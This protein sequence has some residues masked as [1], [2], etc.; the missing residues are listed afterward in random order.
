MDKTVQDPQQTVS[1]ENWS[2]MFDSWLSNMTN[3]I[4]SLLDPW[5]LIQFGLIGACYIAALGLAHILEK[6]FETAIRRISG[7]PR[8]LR[9]LAVLL[10]RM[11]WIVFAV[12]LW[13][14]AFGLKQVTW[15]SRSYFITVAANLVTAWVIIAIVSR[16]IRNRTIAKTFA[17][18]A[19]SLAT[20]NILGFLDDTIAIL[21]KLAFTTGDVRISVLNVAQAILVCGVLVW[22]ANFLA[23]FIEKQ[24][25]GNKDLTPSLQ[26]LISKIAKV[27]LLALAF[28]MS[29]SVA[30]VDLTVLTIF[31]GA[32]GLGIGFGLQKVVSNL[33]SGTIILLDKSIKPGDVISLGEKFG[34]ITSLRARYVS[35]VTRDGVEHLIPN[36]DFITQQVVNWSYSNRQVRVEISFGVSYNS[37]PH[38]VRRITN[39]AI[40]TLDRVLKNPAPVCHMTAFG[41]SSLDFVLRFWIKDPEGGLTNIRGQAFLA[42]WDAFQEEGIDI[43]FPHRELLVREPI[44]VETVT[45]PK[46][47]TQTRKSS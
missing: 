14:L 41:D 5:S 28:L 4:K 45:S 29:L 38:D 2:V 11:N 31:S 15:P 13:C 16:F 3:T 9:F 21:H 20:L 7:Q 35:V 40:Q 25:K 23:D 8:L 26:V 33:I 30:G 6:R 47:R 12:F 17:V 27:V 46:P 43:P 22:S 44:Q 18:T 1:P 34:W 32:I 24:L 10:R 19:W 42:I 36:E 39:E 37:N